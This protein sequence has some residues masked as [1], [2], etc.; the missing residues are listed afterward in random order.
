METKPPTGS[1]AT[2]ADLQRHNTSEKKSLSH[3]T[4]S[5]SLSPQSRFTTPCRPRNMDAGIITETLRRKHVGPGQPRPG[6]VA[7]D[8][9][10][11]CRSLLIQFPTQKVGSAVR[12]GSS[13]VAAGMCQAE[14]FGY[15]KTSC[16]VNRSV[17]I[18]VTLRRTG[19]IRS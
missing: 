17:N 1:T 9:S 5:H 18:A 2:T 16:L 3:P 8:D 14:H 13:A 4:S 12:A 7:F 19:Y 10:I 15:G 6:A 11:S